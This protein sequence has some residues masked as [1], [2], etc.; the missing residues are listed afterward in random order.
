MP[1][2]LNILF[3]K[4]WLLVVSSSLIGDRRG[5]DFPGISRVFIR[6]HEL[7]YATCRRRMS[8][9]GAITEFGKK[10]KKKVA[11]HI[12]IYLKRHNMPKQTFLLPSIRI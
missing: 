10:K 11:L 4:Y 1:R 3:R 9:P 2:I 7:L 5:S 12:K 8:F 6:T